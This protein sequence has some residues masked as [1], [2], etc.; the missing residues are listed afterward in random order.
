MKEDPV[1]FS[2][3]D[4]VQLTFSEIFFHA[5]HLSLHSGFAAQSHVVVYPRF[6]E[7]KSMLKHLQQKI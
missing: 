4:W 7:V 1:H 3:Y 2:W 5:M 6:A